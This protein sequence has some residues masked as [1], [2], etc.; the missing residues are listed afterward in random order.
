V[1][2]ILNYVKNR[3]RHCTITWFYD[4]KIFVVVAR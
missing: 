4:L 2:Q 1:L 3:K